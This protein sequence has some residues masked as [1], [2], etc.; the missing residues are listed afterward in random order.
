ML[1]RFHTDVNKVAAALAASLIACDGVIDE[2]EKAVAVSVGQS[3]LPGFSRATF[4][5]ML[6]ELDHLPSPYE[7]ARPL[8]KLLDDEAKDRIMDYLVA[9]AG[10]D[11]EVVRV[12]AEEIRGVARGLGVPMPPLR[13]HKPE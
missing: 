2:E 9:V 12:E 7:L 3:M 10:A 6:D 1:T 5:H 4:E 13:I 11:H 8:R